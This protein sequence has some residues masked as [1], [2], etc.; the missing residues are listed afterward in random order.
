[1]SPGAWPSRTHEILK[2]NG[3]KSETLVDHVAIEEP[4]EI[5]VRWQGAR[6][7]EEKS[8]AITMRTPGDDFELAAGFL[9]TERVIM[10]RDQV[11]DI[12]YCLDVDDEQ[13]RNIVTV[14]LVPG[15]VLD[16]RRLERNFFAGSSCGVCGK[17]TLEAL[18]L[19]GCA[20]ITGETTIGASLLRALPQLM[21]ERQP[22]FETTG[23][24]HA[25]A[26]FGPSRTM[27]S[28]REDVGRHNAV[29]KIVGQQ[30][31]T[32]GLPLAAHTLLVS[33]RAGYEI[34]QKALV[35][36]VPI[37]AAIGA[38]S[39]LAVDVAERFGMTLVGFLRSDGF[40]IYSHPQ[41]VSRDA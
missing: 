34:L 21:R 30:L 33:G 20:A 29:D 12:A 40:N 27:M 35:A 2:A 8:I 15:I 3:E 24:L 16:V 17:A 6:G 23:G 25:A 1:M 14:T 4:L 26:L 31:M 39:S 9:F 38:P 37:V 13:E 22:T 19:S 41:R 11:A 28:L 7:I 5:R 18:D 32:G 10:R 36:G